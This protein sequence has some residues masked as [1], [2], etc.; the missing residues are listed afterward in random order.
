MKVTVLFEFSGR[1]R[2]AFHDRG[3]E[4]TSVDLLETELPGYGTHIVGDYREVMF[5]DAD[6]IIAHPPCTFLSNSGVRWLYEN[7]K[8]WVMKDDVRTE[9]K[10]NKERWMDMVAAAKVFNDVLSAFGNKIV[11]EN[12]IQHEHARKLI[13]IYDQTVHP[14][15][16]GHTEQKPTC[17]WLKGVPP[18][19]ETNNVY[20]EM[21]QL[22]YG[23]RAKIHYASPGPERWKERS[24]TYQGIADAMAEQWG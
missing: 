11:V 22:D 4:V 23:D 19:V 14:Y 1:V 13:R 15:Q 20:D 21:M 12:P 16:F 17:L 2:K 18:L 24:R 7:G 10:K 3:H 8:R 9:N 6:L 5:R